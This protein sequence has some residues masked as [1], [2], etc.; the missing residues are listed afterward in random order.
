MSSSASQAPES[1][2]AARR[3]ADS[4]G[5]RSFAVCLQR[6]CDR[7]RRSQIFRWRRTGHRR[8]HQ[9]DCGSEHDPAAQAAGAE[10]EA[11]MR[12]AA[13]QAGGGGEPGKVRRT[14]GAGACRGGPGADRFCPRACGL[15]PEDRRG[16]GATGSEHCAQGIAPRSAGGSAAA[17]GHRAG[18]A[19]TNRRRSRCGAAVHPQQAA[20]L[21]ALSGGA[22]GSGRD[23]GD[24]GG[25]GVAA[26]SSASCARPWE[27]P[28]WV[29]RCSSKKLNRD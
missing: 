28:T 11:Q 6:S 16:G 7:G 3:L 18:G 23:A 12:E 2:Q 20:E 8:R 4:A 13:R 25:C 21:A 5:S 22:P 17:D 27:L 26:S 19:G 14:A 29:W 1:A 10:R 9:P 24:R 15:L